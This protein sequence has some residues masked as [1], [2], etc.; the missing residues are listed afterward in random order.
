MKKIISPLKKIISPLENLEFRFQK[1]LDL[2]NRFFLFI[3]TIF[4][5]YFRFFV[6]SQLQIPEEVRKEAN[7]RVKEGLVDR[8]VF[9]AAQLEVEHLINETT[10]PNFLRSDTYL[11]YVQ[12]CQ[13]PDPGGCPSPG[14]SREMSLSCGPNTLPTLFEDSEF[15]SSMHGGGAHHP[16]S[17]TSMEMT[18]EV[19]LT[20]EVL[21]RTQQV[22]ALDFK[23]KPEAFAGCVFFSNYLLTAVGPLFKYFSVD[24]FFF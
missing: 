11:Q 6:K 23:R 4:F 3:L 19:K 20:E 2:N 21:M 24:H 5:L 8:L 1:S 10:Y 7:R 17:L 12:S 16:T 13:N 22:R 9:N 15:I 14:S 18:R